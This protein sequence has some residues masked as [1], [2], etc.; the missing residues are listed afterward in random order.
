MAAT[1]GK[2][3][4]TFSVAAPDAKEVFLC[5]AFNNWELD[6]TP[7]K[8]DGKGEWKALVM[9]APGEYEYRLRVDGAWSNDPTADAFV[10]NTFGTENCVRLVK[11]A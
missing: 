7:M 10:P 6:K 11:S 4:V 1:N 8:P 5:G 9:L 2:K 3:R